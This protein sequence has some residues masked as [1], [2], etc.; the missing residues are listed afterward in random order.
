MKLRLAIRLLMPLAGVGATLNSSAQ[1]PTAA[2]LE[3]CTAMNSPTER[4]ACYDR[5]TGRAAAPAAPVTSVTAPAPAVPD[6]AVPKQA[7]PVMVGAATTQPPPAPP[8]PTRA[9]APPEAFGLFSAEHPDSLVL[10]KSL[11]A[12]VSDVVTRRDGH[13]LV[14]LE[15]NQLWELD[16]ADYLLAKGN[17]VTIHR[18]ALGSF[19]MKTPTGQ[20][21]HA[22]RWR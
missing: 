21:F 11:T 12:K 6:A 7:P 17:S 8:A 15:G 20:N 10:Q 1:Q 18:A 3:T 22:K 2:P 4:L 16:G 5:L 14:V 13:Q 9:A 19:I